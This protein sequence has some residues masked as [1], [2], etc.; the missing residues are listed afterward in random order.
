VLI[1]LY[2]IQIGTVTC[3]RRQQILYLKGRVL[4]HIMNNCKT[5]SVDILRFV[6]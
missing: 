6:Y 4:L 3:K 2:K 5:D 1:S